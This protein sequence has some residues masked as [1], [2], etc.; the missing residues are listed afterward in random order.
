MDSAPFSRFHIIRGH[1][2]ELLPLERE[3]LLAR[4]DSLNVLPLRML[5]IIIADRIWRAGEA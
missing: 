4:D 5:D 2:A 1:T 3:A